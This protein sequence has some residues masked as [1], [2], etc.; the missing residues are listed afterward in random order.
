MDSNHLTNPGYVFDDKLLA[1]DMNFCNQQGLDQAFLRRRTVLFMDGCRY[2]HDIAQERW[3]IRF[4][5]YET[6][7][8]PVKRVFQSSTLNKEAAS[9][10]LGSMDDDPMFGSR[11]VMDLQAVIEE[12]KALAYDIH[13]TEPTIA[14]AILALE[15]HRKYIARFMS[16]AFLWFAVDPMKQEIDL[17]IR[18]QWEGSSEELNSF[19]EK[20]YRPILLPLSSIEQRDFMNVAQFKGDEL[21]LAIERHR[22]RYGHLALHHIDDDHFPAEYYRGRAYALEDRLEYERQEELLRSADAEI[23]KATELLDDAHLPYELKKKIEFVR[24]FMYLRTESIDHMM[25]VNGAYKPIIEF[26]ARQ[27]GLSV[28]IIMN[29]TY[30]E[31]I[32]SLSVGSAVPDVG[33]LTDRTEN[34]YAYFIG[35]EHAVLVTGS[36]IRKLEQACLADVYTENVRELMGQIAFKGKVTGIARVILDR[37]DAHRL[38]AGEILVTAMTAPDFVPAMKLSAGIITDEGGVLCHAAIMSRELRKPCII[39]VKIAT[40]VIRTGQRVTLDADHGI[41]ILENG[42]SN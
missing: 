39:G 35:P 17:Q 21:E 32:D 4:A 23:A 9:L 16:L 2:A 27:L 24:W 22:E 40:D 41:I 19:L 29:M 38:R 37:R 3:A 28:R 10:W 7:A 20:I 18:H 33:I 25:S 31:L 36:D 14:G 42:E 12:E 34:G 1:L 13:R 8:D 30:K 26:S 11:L 6:G 15:K 5:F